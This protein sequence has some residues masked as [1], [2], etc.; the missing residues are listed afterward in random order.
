MNDAAP[1]VDACC[2][3]GAPLHGPFCSACGQ[4]ARPL[5]PP[6][7][8][9]ARDFAHELL[10]VDGRI[11]RSLRRLFLSPGFLTRELFLG[12]RARWV[13]PLRL[14]LIFSVAYFA[15]LTLGGTSHVRISG[16]SARETAQGLEKLGFSSEEEL[17]TTVT[18]AQATWM[19]RVNFVLVPLFAWLLSRVRRSSDRRYPQHLLFALHAHAAWFGVRALTDGVAILSPA[20]L[21]NTLNAVSVFYGMAWV[22][23]ALREAYGITT[24]RAIRDMV[25]LLG[26]YWICVGAATL[27]IILPVV[28]SRP[29]L[30]WW[31]SLTGGAS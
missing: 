28:F 8:V 29:I 20:L 21:K 15:V 13:S 19:P 27:G 26:V 10:D 7:R 14:Y 18:A 2:N 4:E 25:T 5:D 3:C 1:R 24:R 9:V 12:R 31:Q 16:D 30:G 23:I 17:R 22:A 11:F 6:L